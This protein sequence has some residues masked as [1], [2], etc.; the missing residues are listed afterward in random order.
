VKIPGVPQQRFNSEFM[1]Q[2]DIHIIVSVFEIRYLPKN[3]HSFRTLHTNSALKHK[4]VLLFMV[5]FR[6]T[7]WLNRYQPHPAEPAQHTTCSN[8]SLVLL[9]MGIMMPETC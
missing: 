4:N 1:S 3:F 5:F 8:T 2:T 9:K 6:R 7:I